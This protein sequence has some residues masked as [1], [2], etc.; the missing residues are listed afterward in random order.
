VGSR[1]CC[2]EDGGTPWASEND[3]SAPGCR[4]KAAVRG[5]VEIRGCGVS[6][7][8]TGRGALLCALFVG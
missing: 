6:A 7:F 4:V 2:G 3:A 8:G 5:G 1:R